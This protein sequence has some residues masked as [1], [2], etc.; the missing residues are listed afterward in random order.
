[1]LRFIGQ[2]T[3]NRHGTR[4]NQKFMRL[5]W[6]ELGLNWQP[7]DKRSERQ[8]LIWK[9][10]LKILELDRKITE[11]KQFIASLQT[12][13]TESANPI[14]T[15]ER[16]QTVMEPSSPEIR[17]VAC[18]SVYHHPKMGLVKE[19]EAYRSSQGNWI[20][21]N[22][23]AKREE[24]QRNHAAKMRATKA[25]KQKASTVTEELWVEPPKLEILP[26]E[27]LPQWKITVVQPTVLTV[28]AKDFLEA[29]AQVAD[30]GEIVKVEKL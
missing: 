8:Y 20:C 1:M 28:R 12:D 21:L 29:A 22:C 23:K 2:P 5:S 18:H 19:V 11:D 17:Q 30:K 10:S 13:I 26:V 16:L 6:M 27:D 25:V 3:L 15:D 7:A 14:M 4:D 9:D 24:Y